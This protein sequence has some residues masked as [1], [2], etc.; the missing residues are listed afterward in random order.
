M[1]IPKTSRNKARNYEERYR[2]LR[3]KYTK[4]YELNIPKTTKY[5]LICQKLREKLS[6]LYQKLRNK[7]KKLI[8]IPF[9]TKK[10]TKNYEIYAK[11]AKNRI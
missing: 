4:N 11:F 8:K 3:P 9:A 2:K 10:Y 7:I 1:A 5:Y 6:L